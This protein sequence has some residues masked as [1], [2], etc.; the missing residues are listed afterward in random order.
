MATRFAING[1]YGSVSAAQH[2][3]RIAAATNGI[4]R[5]V[6]VH[7]TNDTDETSEMLPF[8]VRIATGTAGVGTA[9]SVVNMET[10]KSTLISAGAYGGFSA[11]YN[12]S[13]PETE[14]TQIWREA[15]NI[16]SGF[17]FV[18]VPESRPV[19]SGGDR[20]VINLDAA[21]S[22]TLSLSVVAIVEIEG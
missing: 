18:P 13:T 17:H 11:I 2:C 15:V 14:S 5:L 8:E 9:A 20:L 6:E 7:V 10:D 1:N 22:N 16:L 21:P 12:L 3:L 19:I 4:T